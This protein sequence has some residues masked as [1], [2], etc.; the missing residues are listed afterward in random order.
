MLYEVITMCHF[1]PK[2]CQAIVEHFPYIIGQ[3]KPDPPGPDQAL[4]EPVTANQE[5]QVEK[6]SSDPAKIVG[7]W[8]KGNVT[9]QGPKITDVVG[10]ALQFQGNGPDDPGPRIRLNPGQCLLV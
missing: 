5:G 10:Q 3:G 4:A 2:L 8:Q 9:A 7:R 6:I 1:G